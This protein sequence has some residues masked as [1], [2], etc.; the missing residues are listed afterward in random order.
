[1]QGFLPMSIFKNVLGFPGFAFLVF[2]RV[3]I[4][5]IVILRWFY[6]FA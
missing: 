1:M 3:L 2:A 4:G 5:F 6:G